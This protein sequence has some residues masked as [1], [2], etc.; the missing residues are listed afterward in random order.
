MMQ[1]MLMP[2]LKNF[3]IQSLGEYVSQL[4][5]G[6]GIVHPDGPKV[7]LLFSQVVGHMEVPGLSGNNH[8][9]CLLNTGRVVLNHWCRLSLRAAKVHKKMSQPHNVLQTRSQCKIFSFHSRSTNCS[10]EP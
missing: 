3:C 8:I 7:H 10:L 9:S 4:V 5:T 6:L 1:H 2:L